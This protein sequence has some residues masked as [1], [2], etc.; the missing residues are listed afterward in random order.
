MGVMFILKMQ[1]GFL[2]RIVF[3]SLMKANHMVSK[4]R[5]VIKYVK[6]Y[7]LFLQIAQRQI[8]VYFF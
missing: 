2:K 8:P 6:V 4:F 5:V 7:L 3:N 1:Y